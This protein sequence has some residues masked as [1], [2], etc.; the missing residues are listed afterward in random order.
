MYTS[1]NSSSVAHST[2]IM[3]LS[4]H[5]RQWSQE[6]GDYLC[7]TYNS[8]LWIVKLQQP[9]FPTEPDSSNGT[10]SGSAWPWC[11]LQSL[12]GF[13]KN[14]SKKQARQEWYSDSIRRLLHL[15]F[16]T[17]L[18]YMCG[19]AARGFKGFINCWHLPNLAML[20]QNWRMFYA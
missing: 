4:C 10:Q 6:K 15:C 16:K 2:N 3:C 7:T 19:E 20:F 8:S 12:Y 5:P 14:G 17:S 11:H 1:I 18:W 13:K 9:S